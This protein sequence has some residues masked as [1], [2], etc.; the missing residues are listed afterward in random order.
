MSS[1]EESVDNNFVRN[2]ILIII[3][4]FIIYIERSINIF[5]INIGIIRP[6]FHFDYTNFKPSL[7]IEIINF[8]G[9]F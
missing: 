3:I 5:M 2:I 4:I 6:W 8:N 7:G 1:H 9:I